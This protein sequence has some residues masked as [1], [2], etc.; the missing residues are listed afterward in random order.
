MVHPESIPRLRS[1][2]LD[3]IRNFK[4]LKLDF[5]DAAASSSGPLRRHQT[6]LVIGRNGTNKSTLL[7]AL[8][9]AL[10]NETDASAMLAT[11]MGSLVGERGDR[12]RIRV[13]LATRDGLEFELVRELRRDGGIDT[14]VGSHGQS[15]EE[16]GLFV[17]G[18]GAGRGV[19]GTD[20]G[21]D[22]RV[23][24]ATGSLFDYRRELL[25]PE[26]V[27]R[28]LADSLG[29]PRFGAALVQIARAIG[30]EGENPRI[31]FAKG[32]GVAITA[33]GVGRQIPL[34]G[35]ADGFRVMFSWI[36]DAYGRTLKRN[37]LCED[38]SVGGL[39]LIDEIDQHLHP[40]LQQSRPSDPPGAD[41]ADADGTTRRSPPG[42]RS[43]AQRVTA[44]IHVARER[45][46]EHGQK[47]SSN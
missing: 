28:R 30:L 3:N 14:L 7:R 39:I 21:R 34:E 8:A 15:A 2:E 36:I 40:Q 26:L 43:P 20:S 29:E 31:E 24:D 4:N 32:G 9:L 23:F 5:G 42:D 37:W 27:L 41:G 10:A 18:Y 35:L 25:S 1:L 47:R 45:D 11:E 17:C 19:T 44:V 46:D 6:T 33:D 22:Y 12:A 38:G 13:E 16:M